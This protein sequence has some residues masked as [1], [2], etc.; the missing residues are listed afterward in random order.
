MSEKKSN[1][2]VPEEGPDGKNLEQSASGIMA[3][4]VRIIRIYSSLLIFFFLASSVSFSKTYGGKFLIFTS[5]IAYFPIYY[6]SYFLY[7]R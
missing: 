5:L 3:V 1:G 7:N 6:Y 2:Q 4:C